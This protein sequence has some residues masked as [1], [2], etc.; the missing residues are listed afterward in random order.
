MRASVSTLLQTLCQSCDG[1]GIYPSNIV[2]VELNCSGSS[3]YVRAGL[4]YSASD[5]GITANTLINILL[6]WMLSEDAPSVL[7]QGST[8][9]LNK[10][11]PTPL[12]A[13]TR[14]GCMEIFTSKSLI[15]VT[16]E[17]TSITAITQASKLPNF[18]VGFF[19]GLSA[20]VLA[21]TVIIVTLAIWYVHNL[22]CDLVTCNFPPPVLV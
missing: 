3:V 21:T 9:R 2:D 7:F 4:V 6:T 19:T 5:G 17:T 13:I 15:S 22:G 1:D 20:G 14:H 18:V 8:M 16:V 10:Q 12:N 11:C